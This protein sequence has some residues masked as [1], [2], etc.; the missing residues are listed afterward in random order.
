M[1]NKPIS[2]LN[3]ALA[4]LLYDQYDCPEVE[5]GEYEEKFVEY[6]VYGLIEKNGQ[7]C[8]YKNYGCEEDCVKYKTSCKEG[9]LFDC[10]REP[11]D[12]WKDF[13][14]ITESEE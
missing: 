9:L 10:E 5:E 11:V 6:I 7:V 3:K 12:I 13:I 1:K 8:P 14:G 4:V 2:N